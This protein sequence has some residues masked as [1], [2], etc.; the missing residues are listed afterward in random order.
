MPSVVS[1]RSPDKAPVVLTVGHSTRALDTFIQ[2]LQAHGVKRL[3]DVRTVP[4]SQ[5]NPQFNRETLPDS[6][7]DLSG[8]ALSWHAVTLILVDVRHLPTCSTIGTAEPVGALGSV[9]LPSTSVVAL[10]MA[11]LLNSAEQLHASLPVGT[12]F[13]S[14]C[15]AV[16]GT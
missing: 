2:L 5:R 16:A 11:P 6:L 1:K 12:P 15:S 10:V 14:G 7:S 13:G 4:R 9:K 8:C 3:V